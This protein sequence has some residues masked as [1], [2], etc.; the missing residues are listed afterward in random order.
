MIYKP[1]C[2]KH[3]EGSISVLVFKKSGILSSS[4]MLALSK[5]PGHCTKTSFGAM[6]RIFI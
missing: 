2:D 5:Y 6:T 4:I 1:T 3:S